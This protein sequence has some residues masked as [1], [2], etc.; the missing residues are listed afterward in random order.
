M[1]RNRTGNQSQLEAVVTRLQRNRRQSIGRSR[2][3]LTSKIHAVDTDTHESDL[4]PKST[5]AGA[6]GTQARAA[7]PR[8]AALF[9]NVSGSRLCAVDV[10][11]KL[12]ADLAE[13]GE[14]ALTT[15]AVDWLADAMNSDLIPGVA[16]RAV[17][18]KGV[19]NSSG[20]WLTAALH[21][22]KQLNWLIAKRQVKA[23]GP[24][25]PP[26]TGRE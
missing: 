24:C 14:A 22:S 7:H 17:L 6:D 20:S 5:R 13:D 19:E 25:M 16:L 1:E 12:A 18:F 23:V 11:G 21:H 3:G 8:T 26:A 4:G 2:G 15:F 10:A 9:A